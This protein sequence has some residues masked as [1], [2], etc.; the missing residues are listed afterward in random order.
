M[1]C[2]KSHGH[3]FGLIIVLHQSSYI[4]ALNIKHDYT[5]VRGQES[6]TF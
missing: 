6:G 1:P 4:G 5:A 3:A 2:D